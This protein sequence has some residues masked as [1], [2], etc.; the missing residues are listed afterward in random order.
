MELTKLTINIKECSDHEFHIIIN[1]LDKEF[2]REFELFQ[3]T[4]NPIHKENM[5]RIDEQR[6]SLVY[7]REE[8]R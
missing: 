8:S 6:C 7:Q 3:T 4:H 1:S 5:E 2:E